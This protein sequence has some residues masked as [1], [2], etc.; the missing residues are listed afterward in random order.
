MAGKQT[1]SRVVHG[2]ERRIRAVIRILQSDL[3]QNG[4]RRLDRNQVTDLS[5]AASELADVIEEIKSDNEDAIAA[6]WGGY[7]HGR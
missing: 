7:K 2:A 1:A 4:S 5:D 6:F 3:V